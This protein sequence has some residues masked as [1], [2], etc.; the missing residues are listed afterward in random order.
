MLL[1]LRMIKQLKFGTQEI[2]PY[3]KQYLLSM[4]MVLNKTL[5]A[6][7]YFILAPEDSIYDVF[8]LDFHPTLPL[9]FSSARGGWIDCWE[10]ETEA[11]SFAISAHE[12][13]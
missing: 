1:L 5:S 4:F 12:G 3:S 6:R 13:K 10:V 8:S 2:F 9:L 11:H 7:I